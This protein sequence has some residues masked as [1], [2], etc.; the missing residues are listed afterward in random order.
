MIKDLI[1]N[2]QFL[3]FSL[4]GTAGFLVDWA[5]LSLALNALGLDFYTGRVVS[6]LV[7]ATFTWASNRQFTFRQAAKDS[8]ARQ[9]QR[10]VGVNLVGG[11]V[12]YAIYAAMVYNFDLVQ[13][14]P[15]IGIAAGSSAGLALN[16]TGS[17]LLVFGKSRS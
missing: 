1:N 7:A 15:V 12:N 2:N 11:L 16:Y 5:T 4:V 13:S 17:R 14:W 9:W 8:P 6:F 3:R 10:F